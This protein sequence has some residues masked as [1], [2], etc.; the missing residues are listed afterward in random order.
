MQTQAAFDLGGQA[1]FRQHLLH[2][3][4][5]HLRSEHSFRW[6]LGH[7]EHQVQHALIADFNLCGQAF[8]VHIELQFPCVTELSLD[9]FETLHLAHI[10]VFGGDKVKGGCLRVDR[11]SGMARQNP[12][13]EH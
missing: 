8:E 13:S 12:Q 4:G 9:L 1:F 3:T 10:D 11:P 2:H 5:V 7:F 6:K